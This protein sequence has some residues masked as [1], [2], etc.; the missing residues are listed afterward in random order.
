MR[1]FGILH[2]L[3]LLLLV[4]VYQCSHAQDLAVTSRGDTIR[5]EIKVFNSGPDK[6]IVINTGNKKKQSIPLLQV[7]NF[8]SRGDLF[9]PVKGPEGYVFMKVIRDG[10]LSLYGYQAPNQVNY[11]E[12]FIQ[13]KDGSEGIIVPNLNFKKMMKK[14]LD[15]CES[16]T[17]KIESGTY[18][19]KDL[20]EIVDEYNHCTPAS[21]PVVA[22]APRVE[23]V[24]TS[25]PW[26]TLAE[27][28]N[29]HPDFEGKSDAV[30][31]IAEIRKKIG[32]GEKVP[33]FLIEGLKNI[34]SK[35]GVT[36]E[37]DAAL[38]ELK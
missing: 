29:A 2:I 38:L 8:T 22:A 19:R 13:K 18:G 35:T 16:V 11:D 10:Y 21:K 20:L 12:N 25:P 26:E 1:T 7:R 15:E 28:V 37:L 30:D 4:L 24:K 3:L 31:M 27:K 23:E 5:G 6:K 32:R 36:A 9:H 14:Y 33:N 34:L 17:S